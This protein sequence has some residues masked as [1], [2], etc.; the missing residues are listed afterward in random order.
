[1]AISL[2]F[3]RPDLQCFAAGE[4]SG[5]I[6]MAPPYDDTVRYVLEEIASLFASGEQ[7]IEA[8]QNEVLCFAP[9]RRA[10][11]ALRAPFPLAAELRPAPLYLNC[12]SQDYIC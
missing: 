4:T 3:R 2:L 10:S 9:P 12:Y 8:S 11:R 1:M 6:F 7:K 5:A